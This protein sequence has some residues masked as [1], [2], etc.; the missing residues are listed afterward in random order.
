MHNYIVVVGMADTSLKVLREADSL[1]ENYVLA[2]NL[3]LDPAS[4]DWV[5]VIGADEIDDSD[6]DYDESVIGYCHVNSDNKFFI[7][8]QSL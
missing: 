4:D 7:D 5:V 1:P 2:R 8:W 6:L 3:G